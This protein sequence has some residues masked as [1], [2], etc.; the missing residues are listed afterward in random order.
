[1][2]KTVKSI[3]YFYPTSSNAK[4][5]GFPSGG[6]SVGLTEFDST[7]STATTI[8][9]SGH[10]T[11]EEAIAAASNMPYEWARWSIPQL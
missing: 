8:E 11:K 1:M 3:D 2:K 6:Y 5:F 7:K 9:Q 4:R 10:A